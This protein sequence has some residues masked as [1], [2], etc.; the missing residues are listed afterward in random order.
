MVLSQ[1]EKTMCNDRR[2]LGVDWCWNWKRIELTMWNM[3]KSTKAVGR[4]LLE[5]ELKQHYVVFPP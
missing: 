2:G 5:R 1:L 4:K 3:Q